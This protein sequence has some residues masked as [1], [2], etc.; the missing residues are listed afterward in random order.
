MAIPNFGDRDPQLLPSPQCRQSKVSLSIEMGT[1][2]SSTQ[3][4][5]ATQRAVSCRTQ[6][7]SLSTQLRHQ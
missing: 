5:D 6:V 3:A 4:D 1:I 7:I 2:V